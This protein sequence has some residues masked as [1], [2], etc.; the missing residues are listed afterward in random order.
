M[1][2]R[3]RHRRHR[4]DRR[5]PRVVI[6]QADTERRR[7]DRVRRGSSV[8]G[9]VGFGGLLA[10]VS[11]VAPRFGRGAT[12]GH[13]RRAGRC[14]LGLGHE[15][16]R[17]H[18]LNLF[19]AQTLD[20]HHVFA[21]RGHA[22]GRDH[23]MR[24][25][26]AAHF[27]QHHIGGLLAAVLR[28]GG[29]SQRERVL[30][31]RAVEGHRQPPLAGGV[32]GVGDGRHLA[33]IHVL[34][35]LLGQRRQHGLPLLLRRARVG[36]PRLFRSGLRGRLRSA[37]RSLVPGHGIG[38]RAR[39]GTLR[40]RGGTLLRGCRGCTRGT[41][42]LRLPIARGTDEPDVGRGLGHRLTGGLRG[43]G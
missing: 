24:A 25:E 41:R 6:L 4:R 35:N 1:L 3:G 12:G 39:D 15:N 40:R 11:R 37:G 17:L 43:T 30:A 32:H 26:G 9:F 31:Q 33:V 38:R 13:G 8:P 28:I 22:R 20:G 18:L 7:C 5:H 36:L 19:G 21:V 42:R 27:I 23:R 29:H 10:I 14:G 16:L 34:A 2:A